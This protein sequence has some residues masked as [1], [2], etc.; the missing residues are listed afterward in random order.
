LA[1]AAPRP[2]FF[3]LLIKIKEI[4]NFPVEKRFF[5][6][7]VFC[8]LATGGCSAMVKNDKK[9]NDFEEELKLA[10]TMLWQEEI[11]RQMRK[12]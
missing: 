1:A 7:S 11:L 6:N 2:G 9:M 4:N 10:A 8:C 3:F 12:Q 5:E